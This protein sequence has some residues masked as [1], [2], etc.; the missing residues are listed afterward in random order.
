M[1]KQI[2]A[3]HVQNLVATI[4]KSCQQN[5]VCSISEILRNKPEHQHCRQD[6]HLRLGTPNHSHVI[7]CTS[8]G[9]IAVTKHGF[10]K[11]LCT[12]T[13]EEHT[14]AAV[15]HQCQESVMTI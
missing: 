3:C 2:L 14:Q 4:V 5:L 1:L 15:F 11:S 12:I 8:K 13:H 7:P 9:G 10:A 6:A